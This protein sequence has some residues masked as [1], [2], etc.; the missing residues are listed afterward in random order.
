M[1]EQE[2]YTEVKAWP[3]SRR[4]R[5]LIINNNIIKYDTG[6]LLSNS[7]TIFSKDEI[8]EFRCGIRW[9]RGLE[10]Y[11]GREYQ[12]F[13][14]NKNNEEIGIHF[15][16]MYGF[17]RKQ[18]H[19]QYGQII[20]ALWKFFFWDIVTSYLKKFSEEVEFEISNV[21]FAKQ[22]LTIKSRGIMKDEKKFIPWDKVG[23]HDY[24]TYFAIFAIDDS[25]NVNKACS[26][27]ED[28]N[29]YVLNHLIGQILKGKKNPS[30]NN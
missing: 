6:N 22:G 14:R 5:P 18:L 28:W 29:T 7:F 4:S 9:I 26:Y 2:Y 16:T 15:K 19:H 17:K 21:H 20:E 10:F 1:N 27:Q 23:T 3:F 30:K 12:V 13:I 8:K 24:S 11:I 25:A